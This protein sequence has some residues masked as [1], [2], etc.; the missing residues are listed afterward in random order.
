M[1]NVEKKRLALLL[2]V[3][4]DIDTGFDLLV[5]DPSQCRLA[6][7]VELSPIDRL[8]AGA[9]HVEP[10]ELGWPRQAAGMGGQNPLVAPPHRCL[11]SDPYLPDPQA[12]S[13]TVSALG[14]HGNKFKQKV[15]R[16]LCRRYRRGGRRSGHTSSS[17]DPS[18]H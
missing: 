5:D 9:A 15:L 10:G 6:Y 3:V 17:F 1:P 8:A 13:P 4:A 2:A 18:R 7:P 16:Q 14:Y 12:T 11:P